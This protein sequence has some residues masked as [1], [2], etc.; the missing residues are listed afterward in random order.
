MHAI[1]F[2]DMLKQYLLPILLLCGT[3]FSAEIV[4]IGQAEVTAWPDHALIAIKTHSTKSKLKEAI[5]ESEKSMEALTKL[6]RLHL[7]SSKIQQ[8]PT[9]TDRASRYNEK[10]REYEFVGFSATQEILIRVDQLP[11]ISELV[12][13]I[14]KLPKVEIDYIDYQHSQ[15]DSLI[16]QA[17]LLAIQDGLQIAKAMATSQSMHSIKIIRMSNFLGSA[18]DRL[19]FHHSDN[20]RRFVENFGKGFGSKGFQF[21][22]ETLRFSRHVEL[23]VEAK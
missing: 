5:A 15:A 23:M 6:I 16:E 20:V 19:N 11:I 8:K 9:C 18:S 3:L 12:N 10:T 21:S 14:L 13:E 4:T 2:M 17:T 22:P 1:V 7:D